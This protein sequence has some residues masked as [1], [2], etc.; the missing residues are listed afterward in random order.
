MSES[1]TAPD[2]RRVLKNPL[3]EWVCKAEW[4]STSC[5]IIVPAKNESEAWDKAWKKVARTEGG[6]SCLKVTVLRRK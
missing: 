3:P 5:Q 6:D 1:L 2:L 4:R